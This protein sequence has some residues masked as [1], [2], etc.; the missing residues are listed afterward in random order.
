MASG[1]C[2]PNRQTVAPHG[3]SRSAAR[4]ECARLAFGMFILAHD[5]AVQ[6]PEQSRFAF[7][8]GIGRDKPN[9][10]FTRGY[11]CEFLP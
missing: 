4:D 3:C 8:A 11:R 1:A 6:V 9:R 10:V 5:L 7:K 2:G